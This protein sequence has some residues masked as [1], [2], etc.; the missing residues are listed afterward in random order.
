[1]TAKEKKGSLFV[2]SAPSGAGK[3]TLLKRLFA[4]LPGLEYSVSSTTRSPRK[5]EQDGKDYFFISREDFE[6]GIEQG[7]WVEWAKVHGN[8]YGTSQDYLREAAKRGADIVL[9]I[10]VQGARQIVKRFPD[11]VTIF[12]LPPSLDALK[13]R[14]V[15]RG[16]DDSQTIAK[17]LEAAKW[18]M[19]QRGE[20]DHIIVN[21]DLEQAVSGLCGIVQSFRKGGALGQTAS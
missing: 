13:A 18:E 14:L 19:E 16:T 8:Y 9:D 10:D 5:G 3:T 4:C 12:V 11:A 6:Q 21:D 15:K 1:M 20:F 2:V 7:R 17:R